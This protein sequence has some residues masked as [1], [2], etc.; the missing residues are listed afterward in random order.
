MKKYKGAF[1]GYLAMIVLSWGLRIIFYAG[2]FDGLSDEVADFVWSIISQ[3]VIMAGIPLLILMLME[4]R[5]TKTEV[6][7]AVKEITG[8][9]PT[10]LVVLLSIVLGVLFLYA[11][12]FISYINVLFLM[13]IG[14]RL[15]FSGAVAVGGAGMFL[16]TLFG[17]AV[18]PGICEEVLHRGILVRGL[19][20]KMSDKT[21]IVL[22]ALLFSFMH[23]N[24]MQSLYT[25]FGGLV[26]GALAVK[27]KSIYP[28]M[29]VHFINN[30]LSAYATYAAQ[31]DWVFSGLDNFLNDVL[32][33][34]L[35]WLGFLA[36]IPAIIY[37]TKY[38][39]AKQSGSAMQKKISV[40]YNFDPVTGVIAS[41]SEYFVP[42]KLIMQIPEKTVMYYNPITGAPLPVPSDFATGAE[43]RRELIN[44]KTMQYW[45]Q[46]EH[47]EASKK[48]EELK[49]S[50]RYPVTEDGIP[51]PT[52]EALALLAKQ[53]KDEEE[54]ARRQAEEL[55]SGTVADEKVKYEDMET[56]KVWLIAALVAGAIY[57]L[58]TFIWGL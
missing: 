49:V 25:F 15:Q 26:L 50:G 30:G 52:I 51:L 18:L 33:S 58:F 31:N 7:G 22:T 47:A 6:L 12:N 40:R 5:K 36:S 20:K 16:L 56:N 57:T 46:G 45:T 35:G 42:S 38:I 32:I 14:Y 29:I 8:K 34:P 17:T 54:A 11:T 27:G 44:P 4:N 41:N 23:T 9:P 48:L 28:A 37:L 10:A 19:K 13:L 53:E 43:V 2:A 1:I 21:V 55:Q 39:I 24:I 3:V